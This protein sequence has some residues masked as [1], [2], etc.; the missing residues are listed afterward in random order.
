MAKGEIKSLIEVSFYSYAIIDISN[1][2]FRFLELDD[3]PVVGR[4]RSIIRG[5]FKRTLIR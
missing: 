5:E 1:T 2:Q 3:L 4:D